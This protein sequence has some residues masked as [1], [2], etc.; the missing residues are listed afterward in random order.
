MA[1]RILRMGL[2]GI[3]VQF[4]DRLDDAAN[5]RAL[6]FGAR[7]A[8]ALPEGVEE[9][10]PSLGGVYLRLDPL[11]ADHAAIEARLRLLLDDKASAAVAP[12]R[13]WTVPA[14][15]GGASG[16]DL[17]AVASAVGLGAD[18]AMADLVARPLRVMAIGF[19]PGLPY[20]GILPDRWNIPRKAGL[21]PKVPAGGVVVAVRQ[22][23]IFPTDT[24]TGWWH[25]GQ[26]GF[27]GFRPGAEEPFLLR[28]GDE[29]Q[30]RP[31]GQEEF[32]ALGAEDP[33]G[34]GASV[35]VVSK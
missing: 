10:V 6:A 31:V 9:V 13:R 29:V 28:P 3:L 4:S 23:I 11:R 5:R 21:T 19:A 18:E 14:V 26:T 16:P 35:E 17:D 12:A 34:G 1:P 15:F 30:L 20:M 33:D 7:L 32:R 22:A 8:A 24:P 2:A 25:V 27:R